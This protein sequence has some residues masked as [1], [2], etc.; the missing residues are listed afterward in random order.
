MASIDYYRLQASEDN[1]IEYGN[2]VFKPLK[3]RQFALYQAAKPSFE[4]M[5]TSLSPKYAV[6][7][8]CNCLDALDRDSQKEGKQTAFLQWALSVLAVSIGL[9]PYNENG[10]LHYHLY[11]V[12]DNDGNIAAIVIGLN[13][14]TILQMN[15][16]DEIRKIIAAL[17]VYEIPDEKWNPEL[18]RAQRYTAKSSH[19]D[20]D[21][22]FDD[23]RYSVALNAGVKPNEIWDWSIK[24]FI[25]IQDA[26]DRKLNYMIFTLAS[27]SGFVQFKKGNPC[28]SWKYTRNPE[29]PTEFKTIAE[30]DAEAKGLLG[31]TT[32]EVEELQ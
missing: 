4:I 17:N 13:N 16:M 27:H 8:W 12:R 20:L 32:Q 31:V 6:L 22:N 3:V 14:P 2:L 7:S 5:Q 18:V 15:D 10:Q 25:K 26:I 29:M 21:V 28:P 9:E 30:M 1:G 24:D 23:L 19:N 11:E